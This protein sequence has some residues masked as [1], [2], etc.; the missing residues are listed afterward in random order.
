MS[1]WNRFLDWLFGVEIMTM[2]DLHSAE[3]A[4]MDYLDV[5]FKELNYRIDKDKNGC[6]S[7]REAVTLFKTLLSVAKQ[8]VKEVIR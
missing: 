5:Q 1:L 4:V 7:V 6:I 2:D 8:I 3:T